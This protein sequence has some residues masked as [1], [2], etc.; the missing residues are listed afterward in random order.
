[1]VMIRPFRP[2]RYNPTIVPELSRVVA[3][4]YD[5]ISEKKREELYARD[6]HNVI[7]L[8]LN[9]DAD[10][11]GSAA[12]HLSEW[13]SERYLVQETKPSLA[14]Y[15]ENFKLKDGTEF[16][17]SGIIGAVRIEPF[18][19]GHIRPHER[20]FSRAKE[21]RMKLLRAC[22]T[23][24]S[25]IFGLYAGQETALESARMWAAKRKPDMDLVDDSDERHRVWLITDE[26]A[27]NA[28]A[29]G[30]QAAD[31]VIADGHHRYETA[32]AYAEAQRAEGA[33]DPDAPHNFIMMYLANMSDPGL[34]ILPTHRVLRGVAGVDAARIEDLLR[35]HFRLQEFARADADAFLKALHDAPANGSL[36]V[37]LST[38]DKLIVAT[39]LDAAVAERYA[40]HLA[41]S[42]RGLDVAVLDTVVL[43]GLL[44]IDCAAEAQE[45]RVTYTHSDG[46]A[47]EQLDAGADAVFFMKPPRMEDML[48][49]SAAGEVMP[50]KST[51]FFPKLLTGLVFHPLAES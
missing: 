5:V 13:Q 12:A 9:H 36:G 50:Q 49:V 46:D 44:G 40:G 41:P 15:V 6:P 4:P 22:R 38:S 7:R 21:D 34:V 35:R 30:L 18:S 8:I 19:S 25:P 10:P 31:V 11:Y 2:L 27:T 14:Y 3:P 16:E 23:N 43:S 47:L 37:A 39:I 26:R 51:Y 33:S 32:L 24:L 20:T 29:E 45:G 48:S 42:V 17:R 28:I 1:M